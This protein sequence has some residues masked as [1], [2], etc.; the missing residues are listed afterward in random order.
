MYSAKDF[1][2]AFQSLTKAKGYVIT[3]VL[4]LGITLGAL[5]A[6]FN[7]NYQLLASVLP[8]PNADNLVLMHGQFFDKGKL[9]ND[10]DLP[11]PVVIDTYRQQSDKV[12]QRALVA[13]TISVERRLPDSPLLTTAAVT[14]EFLRM[15]NVPMQMGRTF[16]DA[17]GLNAFTPVAVISYATWQRIFHG[18]PQVLGKT[19]NI[20]EIDFTIIG[21]LAADFVEPEINKIGQKAD[22]WLPFD[23]NDFPAVFRTN[24]ASIIGGVFMVATKTPS[25]KITALEQEFSVPA[26]TNYKAAITGMSGLSDASVAIS[27]SPLSDL[28]ERNTA[29]QSLLILAGVFA[30]LLIASTNILNIM[31]A[32]TLK[33]QRNMAIQVALGAQ[34]RNIFAGVFTEVLLLMGFTCLAASVTAFGFIKVTKQLANGLLPRLDELHLLPLSLLVV[35]MLSMLLAVIFAFVVS[36]QMNYRS[37]NNLLQSSGKGTGLQVSKKMRNFL[38]V[39]Q[40]AFTGLL[41]CAGLQV[42]LQSLH[43]ITKSVGYNTADQYQANMSIATLWN[44]T[45]EEQRKNYF[46]NFADLIKQL[47]NVEAVGLTN[48]SPVNYNGGNFSSFLIPVDKPD[49]KLIAEQTLSDAEFLRIVSIPL[50]EGRYYTDLEAN[51]SAELM[52]VNETLAHRLKPDGHVVGM[53]VYRQG[54]ASPTA[55]EIIGVL[56][57]LALPGRVEEG[58]FFRSGI[59]YHPELLIKM[60]PNQVITPVEINRLAA[61]IN[62]QLKLFSLEVTDQLLNKMVAPQKTAAGIAAGLS[63]L[64]LG[65]AAIGIY[66]VFSYSVQLRRF[67]L[68]IRMAIGARPSSIIWQ[69]FKDNLYPV[70][71]GLG[72]A[73]AAMLIRPYVGDLAGASRYAGFWGWTLPVALIVILTSLTTLAALWQIIQVPV[74]RV[75][76]QG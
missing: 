2:T 30:L 5:V 6:A 76:Y 32:R 15:F 67:E 42:L 75:L 63:L 68:G 8:Y 43:E 72:I 33:Q 3:V 37:L 18:D 58:R 41:L 27:V 25:A 16:S 39:S 12:S 55:Y 52:L 40:I 47:P 4:T 62:P 59:N 60:K 46:Y 21:V 26:A 29:H 73:F 22:L 53:R 49:V 45:T 48:G 34:K 10:R 54:D 9:V 65:L 44:S 11:Y 1:T 70:T 56:K 20:M 19:L 13:Y 28:I 7:V 64:A 71:I 31:I 50:V 57:D 36:R 51:S 61:Q 14:P 69:V 66:G 38:I 17:E 74:N 35:I 24:W 23:Y